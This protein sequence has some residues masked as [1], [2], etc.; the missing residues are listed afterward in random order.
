MVKTR[1]V[2][3]AALGRCGRFFRTRSTLLALSGAL[4]LGMAGCSSLLLPVILVPPTADED[5]LIPSIAITVAGH[6]RLVHARAFGDPGDPV[7]LVL[8]GSLSDF[9]SL[10]PLAELANDGYRVVFWDQRGNGLSERITA[11]EY[12]E[13]SIVE[14]IDAVAS[15][16]A[17][18]EPVRLIGHSFGAMYTALY[19]S[20]RPARVAQAIMIEP[21]G[22]N[23]AVFAS[24]F[25]EIINV[26]LFNPKMNSLFWQS[27][28][29]APMSHESADY[30]AQMI[31][32]NG[33]QTNYHCDPSNPTPWP[34]W[35]PG[36]WVDVY[37]GRI[38][39]GGAIGQTFA[40]DFAR[41]VADYPHPVLFIA[42][43]CSALGPAYQ[44]RWH[45]PLFPNGASVV[46]VPNTGHRLILEDTEAVLAAIRGYLR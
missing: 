1:R 24:T 3:T 6:T 38:L 17:G 12:T 18:N 4:L 28:Q 31:L 11:D 36:G 15:H 19:L 7:V 30:R 44:E 16:F 35:R 39:G 29:I 41:R 5:P 27:E 33:T 22:L 14:E 26:N 25:D 13:A 8:H 34:V 10:L 2:R 21:G 46:S 23:G 32:L 43:T 20:D 45:V 42:G 9:R 40:F 37:R